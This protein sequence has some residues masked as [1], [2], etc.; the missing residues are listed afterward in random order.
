MLADKFK[1]IKF[2]IEKLENDITLPVLSEF[3]DWFYTKLDVHFNK[4]T[5]GL[6]L[7]KWDIYY[8]NLW[9]NIGSELN[10]TRPC[11]VYS[12]KKANFWKTVIVIPLKSYKATKKINDFQMIIKSTPQNGLLKDSIV[13]ISAIRQVSKKRFLNKI[14]KLEEN[15]IKLIDQKV[16]LI[17]WLK[18]EGLSPP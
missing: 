4:K 18:K 17:F 11:I 8:V 1:K 6:I 16:K 7:N 12:I 13:D 2:L 3:L 14:W 10:K 9:R 5:P 15:Y